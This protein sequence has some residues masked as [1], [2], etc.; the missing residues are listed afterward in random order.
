M[1]VD[2][3]TSSPHDPVMI[4]Y[5]DDGGP[6]AICTE[7]AATRVRVI[8]LPEPLI[9]YTSTLVGWLSRER[10]LVLA[11]P[12]ACEREAEFWSFSAGT[13]PDI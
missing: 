6:G 3:L 5:R 11:I 12:T 1:P 10:L 8:D 4:G 2:W 7:G 13:C 9:S